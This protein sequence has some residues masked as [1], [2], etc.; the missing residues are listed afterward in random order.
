MLHRSCCMVGLTLSW[1][2]LS[3]G[4]DYNGP[5]E[6]YL[7]PPSRPFRRLRCNCV[8]KGPDQVVEESSTQATQKTNLVII[9]LKASLLFV[10]KVLS[11]HM[12]GKWQWR[13]QHNIKLKPVIITVATIKISHQWMR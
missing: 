7:H 8:N 4:L 10:K 1:L 5:S 3:Y 11:A 2:V 9:H 13:L 6:F 12:N